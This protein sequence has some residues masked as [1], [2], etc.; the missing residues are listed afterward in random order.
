MYLLC[1]LLTSIVI[2]LYFLACCALC[3]ISSASNSI[4]KLP[5]LL[6][7][8]TVL[9]SC[10]LM[11]EC[12]NAATTRLRHCCRRRASFPVEPLGDTYHT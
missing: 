4:I 1:P 8:C 6:F 9:D 12:W 5:S 11:L 7:Q 2:V 10:A 3:P